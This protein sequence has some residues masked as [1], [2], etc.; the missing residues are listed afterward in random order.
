[1]Q[2]TMLNILIKNFRIYRFQFFNLLS[3]C[4]EKS[5]SIVYRWL[6]CEHWVQYYTEEKM[7]PNERRGAK[8]QR[9]RWTRKRIGFTAN[10]MYSLYDHISQHFST[11]IKIFQIYYVCVCVD[12]DV[13]I[14]IVFFM[15]RKIHGVHT[16][17]LNLAWT[18][19]YQWAESLSQLLIEINFIF[20]R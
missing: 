4:G 15:Y 12:V 8:R 17:P 9:G 6:F 18:V 2:M 5:V 1:M 16:L 11:N 20:Q 7:S 19:P 14:H 10:G 3:L 13:C